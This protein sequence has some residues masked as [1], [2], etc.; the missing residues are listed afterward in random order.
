MI[1]RTVKAN[2]KMAGNRDD[3][4]I[5]VFDGSDYSNWKARLLLLLRMKECKMVVER[6]QRIGEGGDN[7]AV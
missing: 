4:R 3:I 2:G 1:Q 6:R 7:T 5:P